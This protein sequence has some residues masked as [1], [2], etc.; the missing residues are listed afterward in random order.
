ML[1]LPNLNYHTQQDARLGE[2][3]KQ[4]QAAINQLGGKAGIDPVGV[5]P[6]P[7]APAQMTVTASNGWFNVTILDPNPVR[8]VQ[9]FVEWDT[10]PAFPQAYP[11]SL[12]PGRTLYQSLGNQTLYWRCYSQYPGSNPSPFTVF[13]NPPTAVVGGGATTGPAPQP[14]QGTG[15]G[16]SAGKDPFPVTGVGFGRFQFKGL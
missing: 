15:S 16:Q 12:G 10:D 9:Y 8:G 1:T 5:Y 4:I 2:T 3:L 14:S 13:G 7:V 6:A 11:H